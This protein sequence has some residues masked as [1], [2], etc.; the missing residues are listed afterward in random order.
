MKK[1]ITI[2]LIM[3]VFFVVNAQNG[4]NTELKPSTISEYSIPLSRNGLSVTSFL[5]TPRINISRFEKNATII[6]DIKREMGT[7]LNL[8]PSFKY[9]YNYEGKQYG[10]ETLGKD[11]FNNITTSD[12]TYEVKVTYGSKS[13]GWT[14][15][16][17][18]T[19]Q[20]GPVDKDAKASDVTVR[21]HVVGVVFNGT[22]EIENKIRTL[23]K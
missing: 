6:L 11:A 19:N 17:G 8:N 10:N 16:D 3:A 7:A 15:V 4:N 12:I 21:V 14:K 2:C 22:S 20:F 23:L 1:L 5:L 18:M 9:S 13:W